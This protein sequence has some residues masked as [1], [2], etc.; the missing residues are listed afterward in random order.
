MEVG[1]LEYTGASTFGSQSPDWRMP[2]MAGTMVQ[3]SHEHPT[4]KET[5]GTCHSENIGGERSIGRREEKKN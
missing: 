2:F 3:P 5:K 4:H 1:C